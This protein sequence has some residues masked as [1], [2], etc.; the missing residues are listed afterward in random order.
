[1]VVKKS[2]KVR[3]KM[4]KITKA[5]NRI[6]WPLLFVGLLMGST[7]SAGAYVMFLSPSNHGNNL[8][9]QIPV[10]ANSTLDPGYAHE[11]ALYGQSATTTQVVS[12]DPGITHVTAGAKLTELAAREGQ[13]NFTDKNGVGTG[14]STS[15][16]RDGSNQGAGAGVPEA[17]NTAAKTTYSGS[18]QTVI[19]TIEEADLVKVV[20]DRLYV[21]NMYRGLYILDIKDPSN[22]TI[23][24]HCQVV[25]QPVEMYVVDT[26][27]IITVSSNYNFWM[28]YWEA[29]AMGQGTGAIGTMIYIVGV[30]HP[31][32]P[33]IY[34]IVELK[35]FASESRRVGHVI[36]QTTNFY[37]AYAYP[38]LETNA[39]VQSDSVE[40]DST[41][42]TSIDF[43]NPNDLGIKDRVTFDS[44]SVQVYASVNAFYVIENVYNEPVT[45]FSWT[46][47]STEQR[48]VDPYVRV[49]YLDI[50]DPNG[51]IKTRDSFRAP[52]EV[53]DKYQMDEFNGM[54]R[55]VT[56]TSDGSG[57][58]W[59]YIFD[60]TNPKDIRQLSHLKID[61]SGTLSATR[62]AGTRAYTIHV[63]QSRDPLDVLDLSDPSAPKLCAKFE[64]PGW[65]T[66]ME[67]H[68]NYIIALGSDNSNGQFNV[69]VSLF[70]VSDPMSPNMLSRVRLGGNYA[71]SSANWEPKALTVD[72]VH[73]LVVV[74]FDNYDYTYYSGQTSG[75]QLVGFDLDKGTLTL[76]GAVRGRNSI[77]RT[78]V[79]GDHILATSDTGMEVI[80]IQDLMNPV[81]E[82]TLTLAIDVVDTIPVGLY[83]VQMFQ[84]YDHNGFGLRSVRSIDDLDAITTLYFLAS[85]GHLLETPKGIVLA[86]D[87]IDNGNITGTL[88][89]VMLA[90]DGTMTVARIGGLDKGVTFQSN[91]YS[92]LDYDGTY[93]IP[94]YYGAYPSV[95]MTM[96]GSSLAFLS[97]GN[98][99]G[100]SWSMETTTKGDY[101]APSTKEEARGNDT[102]YVFD[103]SD[104]SAVPAP[105]NVT[106][107]EYTLIGMF[108]SGNSLYI[109][110]EMTGYTY[111]GEGEYGPIYNSY[112]RNFVTQVDIVGHS[113]LVVGPEYNIPGQ[114]VGVSN[115][116]VYTLSDPQDG[117]TK[118]VLNVLALSDGVAKIVSAVELMDGWSTILVDGTTA[119]VIATQWPSEPSYDCNGAAPGG[120]SSGPTTQLWALD[121][122]DPANPT[123]ALTVSFDGSMSLDRA[124][125]GHL[126]ITDNDR[127][128]VMIYSTGT[129][130]TLTFESMVQMT[131]YE[132]TIKV[133]QDA[134]FVCEGYYGVI[135]V[136]V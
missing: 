45:T 57:T 70:D 90:P 134:V 125:D 92:R 55:M 88:M 34:K 98:H 5:G 84:P 115:G 100:I 109:Q 37:Q 40:Q 76:E 52:G 72:M 60:V 120:S 12:A 65:I 126:V 20:G 94:F 51:D 110:H 17:A 42:V 44:S 50:S 35:G 41:I 66:Y 15:G 24:G 82:K 26:L 117:Q 11:W 103:L 135:G 53:Y 108:T 85:W 75:V 62:F 56:H 21:L 105:V 23:V 4:N 13:N 67:I 130:S 114:M 73:N 121:L 106:L 128:S 118:Q 101:Y 1:M 59:L 16:D 10:D 38:M 30:A 68:G 7:V 132:Q 123:L 80:G 86:A 104:L 58:S 112:Y 91:Y 33:I 119:Y 47:E 6:F 124:Q 71:S 79:V 83:S 133:Y 113:K 8:K 111:D 77:D 54:F 107:N 81:V 25:G 3:R 89:N 122:S 39:K 74:P 43:G 19:R 131:G 127:S 129:P 29:D 14:S 2:K 22:A 48:A 9:H 61:D 28:R 102:L 97:Q 95:D 64:M 18:S 93:A 78:R 116:Y 99:P 49:T 96:V 32:D 63:P 87:I 69:A 46:G 31:A 36:Y 27:A 136:G